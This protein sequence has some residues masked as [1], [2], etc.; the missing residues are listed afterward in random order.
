MAAVLV[1]TGASSRSDVERET[2]KP[3]YVIE[4]LGQLLAL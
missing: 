4:N 1:L 2:P 3:D